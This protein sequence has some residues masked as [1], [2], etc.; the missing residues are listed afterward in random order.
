MGRENGIY[1]FNAL[2][3]WQSRGEK[4]GQDMA[5]YPIEGGLFLAV[6]KELHQRGCI[7]EW[8][9]R[10]KPKNVTTS[11]MLN[12]QNFAETIMFETSGGY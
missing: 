6:S 2:S 7:V 4:V 9:D 3:Y 8:Y 11:S 12:T 5:D 10:F 1:R